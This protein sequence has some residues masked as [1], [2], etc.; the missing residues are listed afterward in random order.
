MKTLLMILMILPLH[1]FG[2][3]LSNIQDQGNNNATPV[4]LSYYDASGTLLGTCDCTL[5]GSSGNLNCPSSCLFNIPG[6]NFTTVIMDGCVYSN[7][8]S[9]ISAL[10][11]ELTSFTCSSKSDNITISWTT[12]TETN[13]QEFQIWRSSDA[14]NF[15]KILTSPGNGTSIS[16][17]SYYFID[18]FPPT[19]TYY[20]KLIQKDYNGVETTSK[21][22]SCSYI[23]VT[24]VIVSYYNMVNQLVDIDNAVTGFYMREYT[25]GNNIKREMYFKR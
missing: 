3:C 18:Y 25:N 21:L 15:V 6:T 20:Y 9:L 14:I 13:N 12:A 22:T 23:Q 10:P 17:N 19:G 4:T 11:I 1:F 2:Q 24:N 16:P 5:A 8:G 7:D